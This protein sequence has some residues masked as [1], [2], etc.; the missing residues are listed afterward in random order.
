M[1]LHSAIFAF[2]N[3]VP[4]IN[5]AYDLK[6]YSFMKLIEQS[7]KLI[8]VRN[9]DS[10][11]LSKAVYQTLNNSKEIKKSFKEMKNYFWQK[12]VSFLNEIQPFIH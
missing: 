6:N 2:G 7:D 12:E 9:I 8:D 5:I 10:E 3:C 4:V 1:Q 11:K